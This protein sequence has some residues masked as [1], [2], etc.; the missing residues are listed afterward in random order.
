MPAPISLSLTKDMQHMAELAYHA[1]QCEGV[2]RVD[3]MTDENNNPYVL[4]VNTVPGMTTTSLV[5][6]A[7]KA[8]GMDFLSLCEA[9]LASAR[10]GKW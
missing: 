9:I 2:A 7:A 5:P 3:I 4:E 8:S 10:T 1:L 6:K